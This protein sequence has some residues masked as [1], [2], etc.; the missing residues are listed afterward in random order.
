MF[1][2]ILSHLPFSPTLIGQLGFYAKR[3]H[4]EETT[5]RLGLIFIVLTLIVQSLAVFQPPESANASSASDMVSGGIGSSIENFLKPYDA[6]T[7]NLRDVMNYLGITRNEIE[8][9]KLSSFKTGEKISWGFV[10]RFSYFQGAR[11]YNITND[12]NNI[13][14]TVYSRP[15]KL[16][17]NANTQYTAWI[18]NSEKIGWFAIMQACGNLVTDKI[19]TPA[20]IPTPTPTPTPTPPEK[21][22]FNPILLANDKNCLPCPGNETIWINDESCIPNIIKSKTATNTTQGFVNAESTVAHAGDQISYTITI[23]N[24]GLSPETTKLEE[25]L[26]DTLEYASLQDNGGGTL[27]ETTKT[28]SW[29]GITLN[30]NDLQTRTFVVK[31]LNEIPATASGASDPTSYDC[32]MS[33]VYGN[34]IN[35]NVDCPTPKIIEQVAKE[36]PKTGPTV[37]MLFIGVVLAVATYFYARNRQ[38]KKE[39]QIVRKNFNSGA[40]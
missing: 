19:P 10:S 12:Q 37:N 27:N 3:L 38:M 18:G 28:L 13:V 24:T 4:H 1:R 33:N 15:L 14:T 22:L 8:S 31:I 23:K 39:I 9:T 29:A 40:I 20:P 26:E 16:W 6:N 30:P 21:C 11:Q 35:I 34:S 17:G 25:Q 36:L 5:R 7:K 2:I 32:I